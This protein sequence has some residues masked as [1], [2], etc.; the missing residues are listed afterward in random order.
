[1]AYFI[2]AQSPPYNIQKKYD[3]WN[4]ALETQ[5]YFT[6]CDKWLSEMARVLKPGGTLAVINIPLWSVRHYQHLTG[7]L[8][9]QTWIAWD[10]LSLPVR[11][12]MP[13]HYAIICFSKGKPRPLPGINANFKS[14]DDQYLPTEE[15]YC[16]RASCI[17][18]RNT[19]KTTDRAAFTDLWHDIFRLKHNSRRVDHPCQLPPSLMRRLFWIYTNPNDLILDC[20]DGAGTTTLVA[21][22]MNRRYIGIEMSAHYH[23]IALERHAMIDRGNDPFG[24][25]SAVP[26]AKNSRVERLP[27]QRYEVSK[28][29]LQLEVR[30]ISKDIGKLPCR[31]DIVKLSRYPIQYFDN[32]FVSWG[33]VCAAARHAGMSELPKKQKA[34]ITESQKSFSFVK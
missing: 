18:H 4:D 1:M 9:F 25:Q 26:K 22:Q 20:F 8:N 6:W 14:E 19:P 15:F 16:N 7:L 21:H 10:G 23:Q 17:K 29:T 32:Y 12:I 30:K 5:E 27:K 28:K 33:E 31:D 34:R 3:H 24:K 13:S 11:M 2:G